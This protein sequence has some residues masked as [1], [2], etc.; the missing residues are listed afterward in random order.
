MNKKPSILFLCAGRPDYPSNAV[1]IR[2]LQKNFPTKILVSHLT[3]YYTRTLSVALR[4]PF[5]MR[6]ADICYVGWMGQQLVP[7]IRLFSKKPIIFDS[8]PSLYDSFIDRGYARKESMLAKVLF[9]FD[10]FAYRQSHAIIMGDS[11]T[12]DDFS[13]MFDIPRE[14]FR[15]FPIC[16]NNEIFYPRPAGKKAPD[17]FIVEFVGEMAPQ[18]GAE[19]IMQAAKHLE[20]TGIVF[21]IAGTGQ[22]LE[23]VNRIYKETQP[24][25]V[26]FVPHRISQEQ[27]L[28]W[29]SEADLCL[30]LFGDTPKARRSLSNKLYE[31]LAMGKAFLTAGPPEA[32]GVARHFTDGMELFWTSIANP[33]AIAEKILWIRDHAAERMRVGQQGYEAY[34]MLCSEEHIEKRIVDLVNET[35]NLS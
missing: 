9:W 23:E 1:S 34:T 5:Y 12:I 32:H 8:A 35:I 15:R 28:Q 29:R 7:L 30:G 11:G 4:L 24:T 22:C 14:K 21:R 19:H 33:K 16:A 20:G 17:K 27:L 6:A 10:Q 26:T 31:A 18:H 2:T 25:N 13:A 3:S